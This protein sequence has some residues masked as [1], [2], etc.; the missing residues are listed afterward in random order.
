VRE[1]I[2]RRS[3]VRRLAR[4]WLLALPGVAIVLGAFVPACAQ[5]PPAP[6]ALSPQTAAAE[7][8]PRLAASLPRPPAISRERGALRAPWRSASGDSTSPGDS[9]NATEG[10]PY[11]AGNPTPDIPCQ[12]SPAQHFA[13]TAD[14]ETST[15]KPP[16]RLAYFQGGLSES[17]GAASLDSLNRRVDE[18]EQRERAGAF[19]TP[20]PSRGWQHDVFGRIQADTVTMGQSPS[21]IAQVGHAP[22]GTELERARVGVQGVGHDVYFYRF[23]TDF[24]QPDPVT[25]LRP[26]ILDAYAEIRELPFGTLRMGQFRVPLSVERVTSANDLTF[27]ERGLPQAFNPAR[28]LGIMAMNSTPNYFFT[29]YSDLSTQQATAEGEQF[30]KAGRVDYT[31]RIVFLPW[32]DEPSEGR[33]LFHV[34]GAYL[35]SNTRNSNVQ[36]GSAPEA[37]L[38]YADTVNVIPN[39]VDTGSILARDTNTVQAEASTVLGPLSFQAEYYG[40][41]VNPT[42]NPL[43]GQKDLFFSGWYV[44]GSYF[45]TGE[46]RV[47]NRTQAIYT[48]VTPFTN[49]FRVRGA[50]RG[51]LTGLGAW[52]VAVRFSQLNLSDRYIQGGRLNDVT[53]GLNW[54]LTRQMKVMANYIYAMNNV[55][56][57]PTYA[58][59]FETRA[60]VVW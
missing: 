58:N 27:I 13:E 25:R 22:N 17:G 47:Y 1:R 9:R 8:P 21:N 32:Y 29:W 57:Q 56:N 40:V 6:I 31:Q 2:C 30:G 48:S 44:F 42:V 55:H 28:E 26:R 33:Y 60:Q 35:Y 39:F 53:C 20:P 19:T 59:V 14:F 49:F 45:L 4:A 18:L 46:H 37:V 23:E 43:A 24:A 51:I 10:V 15:L 36:Y 34:G 5:S 41:F 16:A 54:Y 12:A 50:D 11:R 3:L 7:N 52:E 38:Q